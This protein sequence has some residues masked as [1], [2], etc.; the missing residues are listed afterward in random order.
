MSTE[1][2][3]EKYTVAIKARDRHFEANK[4]VFE[5]HEKFVNDIIDAENDLRDQVAESN[6]GVEN[7]EYKV[8]VA[9]QTQRVYDEEK[10]KA[11]LTKEQFAMVVKDNP[12]PAKI[13]IKKL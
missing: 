3:L 5:A 1:N 8:I 6:K 11:L 12:R 7:G 4:P 9:P 13:T 10:L 2:A